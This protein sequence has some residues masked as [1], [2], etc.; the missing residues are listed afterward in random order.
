VVW[1]HVAEVIYQLWC[2]CEHDDAHFGSVKG[3]KFDMLIV[4]FSGRIC[5]MEFIHLWGLFDSQD[6]RQLVS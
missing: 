1:I 5:S 6:K 4:N 2:L 3:G